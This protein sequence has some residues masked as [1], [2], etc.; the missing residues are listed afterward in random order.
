MFVMG[1]KDLV[2][3]TDHEPLVGILGDRAL[4]DIT[5][6]CL[7]MLKEKTL[8]YRFT[9]QHNPGKWHRGSDAV[10]R[11]PV[12]EV[13]AFFACIRDREQTFSAISYLTD[14]IEATVLSVACEAISNCGDEV[15]LITLDTIR[16]AGKDDGSYVELASQGRDT[17][18]HH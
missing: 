7:T 14:E 6:P 11:G 2:I 3:I 10:S 1:C 4:A 18:R 15:G 16:A 13:R 8:R 12:E 5:N 9:I 17:L